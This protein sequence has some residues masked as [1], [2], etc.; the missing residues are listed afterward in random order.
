[1]GDRIY[2]I[3]AAGGL[4]VGGIVTLA[5]NAFSVRPMGWVE[6]AVLLGCFVGIPVTI[7]GIRATLT[8]DRNV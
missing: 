6:T 3:V 7:V 1:M 2:G 4:A 8:L 5:V